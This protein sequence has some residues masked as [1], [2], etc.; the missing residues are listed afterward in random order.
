[1][2][3]QSEAKLE[4]NLIKGVTANGK[5]KTRYSILPMGNPTFKRLFAKFEICSFK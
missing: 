3:H 5:I 4:N 1:M 2:S